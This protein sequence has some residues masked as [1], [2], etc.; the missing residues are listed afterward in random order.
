M[1]SEKKENIF[2]EA[3]ELF[4]R[5]EG[6]PHIESKL[7]LGLRE[8]RVKAGED[9]KFK[10]DL[11]QA[12][13]HY[14]SYW[15]DRLT[16]EA[17]EGDANTRET[18]SLRYGICKKECDEI[19]AFVLDSVEKIE[20]YFV[21]KEEVQK[22]NIKIGLHN[23]VLS[24]L[25]PEI[26]K[27]LFN[28]HTFKGLYGGRG[29]GKSHTCALFCLVEALTSKKRIVCIRKIDKK[30]DEASV[31]S[32]KVYMELLGISHLGKFCN[33]KITF[34]NG[35][36][37]LFAGANESNCGEFKSTDF[38]DLCWIDEAASLS[39]KVIRTIAA[40]VRKAGCQ[41]IFSWNPSKHKD[42]C[43]D[44]LLE[45]QEH[46]ALT[47]IIKANYY[48]NPFVSDELVGQALALKN[49]D[50]EHY[51]HIWEG[52]PISKSDELIFSRVLK[53][54]EFESPE[55]GEVPYTIGVDWG[56]TNYSAA[57]RVFFRGNTLYIDYES[58]AKELTPNDIPKFLGGIP[59]SNILRT[60]ADNS[61]PLMNRALK[62]WNSNA[63]KCEKNTSE[64]QGVLEGIGALRTLDAIVVHPRCVNFIE[65]MRN[66]SWETKAGQVLDKV[67]KQNDHGVDAMRYACQEYIKQKLLGNR[68]PLKSFFDSVARGY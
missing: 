24:I 17:L 48:D 61:N 57:V 49:K 43:H 53:V 60:I 12:V 28:D 31:T 34:F 11:S 62:E 7:G 42:A 25:V 41:L 37:I 64:V 30:N 58:Y 63:R 38:L 56:Y 22:K 50:Y 59:C 68:R 4:K 29:S 44:Y 54:E 15:L 3:L 52:F 9:E 10:D 66:Y 19:R 27:P 21:D 2:Y 35:S 65:E 1:S 23:G 5:G 33:R 16:E 18:L 26:F 8:L 55:E 51:L 20:V 67:K 32:L 6:L 39:D 36:E 14:Q 13:S 40:T 46:G 47:T 45:Q